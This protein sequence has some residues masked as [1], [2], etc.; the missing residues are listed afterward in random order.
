MQERIYLQMLGQYLDTLIIG[1]KFCNYMYKV[2][3]S[4]I[5]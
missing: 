3:G 1:R 4:T 2:Y 5:H